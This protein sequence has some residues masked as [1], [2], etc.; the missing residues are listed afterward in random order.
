ME[1]FSLTLFDNGWR[2][3]QLISDVHSLPICSERSS[4][5]NS[6][7]SNFK[8]CTKAEIVNRESCILQNSAMVLAN[9]CLLGYELAHRT[10]S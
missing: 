7:S 2:I 10:D 4:M 9:I 3:R 6:T 8:Y 5:H 1:M